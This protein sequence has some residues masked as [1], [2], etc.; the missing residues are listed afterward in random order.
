MPSLLASAFGFATG[1]ANADKIDIT[2]STHAARLIK[3]RRRI[4][5]SFMAAAS[6][7][8]PP[9]LAIIGEWPGGRRVPSCCGHRNPSGRRSASRALRYVGAIRLIQPAALSELQ[10]STSSQLCARC[11]DEGKR[12][13][14]KQLMQQPCARVLF[15]RSQSIFLTQAVGRLDQVLTIEDFQ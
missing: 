7:D 6:C 14:G 13:P 15:Q 10:R 9:H 2:T 1:I 8:K 4:G 3:N 5:P 11:D 12:R